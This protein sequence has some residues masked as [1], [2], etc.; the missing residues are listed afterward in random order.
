ML[1][2]A[3]C[4]KEELEGSRFCGRC[5]APFEPADSQ[6]QAAVEKAS[7]VVPD[8]PE[9]S[10]GRRRRRVALGAAVALL[11]AGGGVAAVLTL[12]G[13][14]SGSSSQRHETMP[15]TTSPAP[16]TGPATTGAATGEAAPSGGQAASNEC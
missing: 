8:P 1:T 4:G 6:P 12:T 2:C 7:E 10:W 14:G 3:S 5:G 11:A 13:G 16:A 15:G 9:P